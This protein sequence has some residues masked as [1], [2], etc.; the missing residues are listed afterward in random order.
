MNSHEVIATFQSPESTQDVAN[1]VD[2]FCPECDFKGVASRW[3]GRCPICNGALRP[4][5]SINEAPSSG[6]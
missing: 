3:G 6:T 5:D 2:V 1:N 4:S